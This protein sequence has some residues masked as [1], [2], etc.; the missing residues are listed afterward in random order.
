MQCVIKVY[1]RKMHIIYTSVLNK[2]INESI[3]SLMPI[4]MLPSIMKIQLKIVVNNFKLLHLKSSKPT[5]LLLLYEMSSS[6]TKYT[7]LPCKRVAYLQLLRHSLRSSLINCRLF[8][9]FR[10]NALKSL[11]NFVLEQPTQNYCMPAT[12]HC[13]PKCL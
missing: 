2:D 13:H 3:S 12:E 8:S 9:E 6:S 1:E 4:I 10:M 5:G 11:G 7:V